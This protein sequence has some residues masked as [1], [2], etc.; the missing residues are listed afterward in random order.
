MYFNIPFVGV[1]VVIGLFAH[2]E[3]ED[4]DEWANVG[5]EEADLEDFYQLGESS[6]EKEEVEEELELMV[7]HLWDEG[8]KVVFGVFDQIGLVTLRTH[9]SVQGDLSAHFLHLHAAVLFEP[10]EG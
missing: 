9:I 5:D 10:F 6:D 4:H 7:E 1:E 2:G 8:K 3:G